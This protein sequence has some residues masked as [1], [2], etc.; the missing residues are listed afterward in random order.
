ML[1]LITRYLNSKKSDGCT[2]VLPEEWCKKKSE[3]WVGSAPIAPRG[4]FYKQIEHMDVSFS[5]F[6]V[7]PNNI[8]ITFKCGS[9]GKPMFGRIYSI[10]VHRRSPKTSQNLWDTWVQVQR[11]PPLPPGVYNPMSQVNVSDVQAHLYA[12]GPTEDCIIRLSEVVAHCAW[13][14]Y[15]PLELHKQLNIPT[16]ALVSMER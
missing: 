16:V 15:K 9:D 6:T 2:W 8:F 12:W 3:E 13:I 1:N 7:N 4:F 5:T 11:F 10:C 14:M